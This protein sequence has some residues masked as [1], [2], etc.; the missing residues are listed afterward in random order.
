MSVIFLIFLFL[1]LVLFVVDFSQEKNAIR[2]NFP[3]IGNLRYLLISLGPAFR[4]YFITS[5]GEE[6]PFNRSQRN[7]INNSANGDNNYEERICFHG[8]LVKNMVKFCIHAKIM[9]NHG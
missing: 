7:W 1:I 3:L 4:Q 9:F 8:T 6:L 5:N 2:R